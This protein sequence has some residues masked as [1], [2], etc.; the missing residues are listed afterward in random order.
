MKAST[1]VVIFI[2]IFI[3][4]SSFSIHDVQASGVEKREQKDCLKKLKLCK[5]NKDCCSKSC[6]RRGTNIEKRCR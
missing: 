4:I 3:T 1:L 6:K 2:V 5:E